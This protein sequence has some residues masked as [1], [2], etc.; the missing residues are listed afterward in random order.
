MKRAFWIATILATCIHVWIGNTPFLETLLF[1]MLVIQIGV[2]GLFTGMGHLFNTEMVA[3]YIGW[4]SNLF[5]KEV[6]YADLSLG[7]LGLMCIW[8]HGEFRLA[9]AIAASIFWMGAGLVHI[10]D[11]RKNNNHNTG[12]GWPHVLMSNFL[13]PLFTL[14]LL[15]INHS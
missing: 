15:I 3:K 7:V 5:Q 13:I 14:T 4:E 1:Y 6:G 9:V 11:I 12:N 10:E 8:F 2:F